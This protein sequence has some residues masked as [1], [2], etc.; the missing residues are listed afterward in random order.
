[1]ENKSDTSRGTPCSSYF[2]SLLY[3]QVP[4]RH[5]RLL[6]R[7]L[8]LFRK[9]ELP[10]RAPLCPRLVGGPRGVPVV[11]IVVVVVDTL[12]PLALH[13]L[14]EGDGGAAGPHA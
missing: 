9:A 3:L 6:R 2:P 11:V 13:D 5:G 10:P 7:S 1:M 8:R 4:W 12:D 14:G